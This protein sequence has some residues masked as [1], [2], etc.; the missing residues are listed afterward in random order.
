VLILKGFRLHRN[1][2]SPS[3]IKGAEWEVPGIGGG[4]T[5][6]IRYQR[7]KGLAREI[8]GDKFEGGSGRPDWS[9]K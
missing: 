1:G 3:L 9:R 6:Q 8:F 2:G 7:N 5:Q 4:F